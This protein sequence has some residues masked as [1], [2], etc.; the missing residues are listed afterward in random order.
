MKREL[1]LKKQ[2]TSNL[3]HHNLICINH[4]NNFN[5][6]NNTNSEK[7]KDHQQRQPHLKLSSQFSGG[8][9]SPF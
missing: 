7:L 4:P 5:N 1:P 6:N 9:V 2:I 8:K 3:S